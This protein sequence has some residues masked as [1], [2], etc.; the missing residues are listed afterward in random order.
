MIQFLYPLKQSENQG[1]RNKILTESWLKRFKACLLG[2]STITKRSTHGR[3][4][5]LPFYPL[6]LSFGVDDEVYNDN[7]IQFMKTMEKTMQRIQVQ[8]QN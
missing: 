7:H 6:T 3:F 4:P 1:Y 8:P 2:N 5:T